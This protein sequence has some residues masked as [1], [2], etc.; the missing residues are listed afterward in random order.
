MSSPFD[1][2]NSI[3]F[4]KE[5][6]M[7]DTEN[8]ELA[9]KGYDAFLSNRSLSY[10][11]D[12]IGMANEMNSRSFLDKKLQYEFL[13]NTIRKRKRFSKW[14]KPEKNDQVQ[15]IQQFYGYSRRKAEE[16]LALLTNDQINEITNKLE[17]GGLKK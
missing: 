8:D 14:I 11:E 10:F 13:L 4:S 1:Y 3:N 12:T 2:V 7:R 16:A 17:K 9:E 5:N 15:I 6:M